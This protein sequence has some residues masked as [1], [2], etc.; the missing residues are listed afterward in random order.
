MPVTSVFRTFVDLGTLL[1]LDDLVA[2]RDSIVS[3]NHRHFGEPRRPVIPVAGLRKLV[4][5]TSKIHGIRAARLAIDL[6]E[7]R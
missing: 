5:H 7:P 2:A 4:E 6:I 3:E 1:H